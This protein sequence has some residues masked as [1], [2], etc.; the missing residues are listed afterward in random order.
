MDTVM[1]VMVDMVILMLEQV[2]DIVMTRKLL[3]MIRRRRAVTRL[4]Q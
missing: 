2:T 1:M 4:V 3:R